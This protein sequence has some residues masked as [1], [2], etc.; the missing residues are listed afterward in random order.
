MC[1]ILYKRAKP[2]GS[3]SVLI[4]EHFD[5]EIISKTIS[6]FGFKSIRGSSS[7]N[8]AKALISSLKILKRDE[9]IAITPDGPRGPFRSVAQGVVLISQKS[10]TPIVPFRI[11]A[12]NYWQLKSWDRFTIPKPFSRVDFHI[13]EPFFLDDMSL[14][15]GSKMIKERMEF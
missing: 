7:K 4:S 12:S 8:G 6:L 3:I 2:K 13:L 10:K 9:D 5:G 14:D 1:P 11:R 15:E